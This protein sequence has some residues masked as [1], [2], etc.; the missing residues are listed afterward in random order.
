MTLSNRI[1]N[2]ISVAIWSGTQ[3]NTTWPFFCG[4]AQL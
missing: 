1:E 3:V 2:A 4:P